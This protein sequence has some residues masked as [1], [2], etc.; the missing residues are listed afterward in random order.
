M[1]GGYYFYSESGEDLLFMQ[2][3]DKLHLEDP[4]YLDIGV[5]HPVIRNN[6][7]MLY[8]R[9][10]KNGILVE[11]NPDMCRLI[12]EYRPGNVLLNMGA[13]ADESQALRYYVS[14][15]PSIVG[16]NTFSEIQ[17]KR[18]GFTCY[19]DIP[20]KHIN[21]IIETYCDGKVDILDLDTEGMDLS[22]INA[23]DTKRYNI[24]IICAETAICGDNSV[25][26][27]LEEKGYVHFTGSWS[28]GIYL[29]K[30]LFEGNI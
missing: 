29:K 9:G 12:K 3:V 21:D 17:A 4:V 6:T 10:Y 22:L 11:P 27:V 30:E 18:L 1:R 15:N 26:K 16:H 19:S 13:C 25:K 2:M 20:V 24:K 23:L 8:E 14:S 28:N 7:Y 5:C